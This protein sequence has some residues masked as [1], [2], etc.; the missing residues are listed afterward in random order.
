[1]SGFPEDALWM[2]CQEVVLMMENIIASPCVDARVGACGGTHSLEKWA[3][4]LI[5]SL[6]DDALS[7][8]E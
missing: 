8:C 1:M 2:S 6:P 3:S 7:G 4:R 5:Q